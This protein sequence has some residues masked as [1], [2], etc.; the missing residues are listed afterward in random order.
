MHTSLLNYFE[1]G[2]L[3]VCP[4]DVAIVDE[5]REFTFQR[6]DHI[7][8]QIASEWSVHRGDGDQVVAVFLPRCAEVI[9]CNLAAMKCGY[10]YM[11]I[12]YSSPENR[13]S[14]ILENVAPH[15]IV[16]NNEGKDRIDQSS[17]SSAQ[18]FVI[19]SFEP[20][21]QTGNDIAPVLLWKQ[22]LDVDPAFIINTSGSTGVPKSVMLSHR[23]NM[24]FIDWVLDTFDFDRTDII[25]SIAPFHFDIYTL[26]LYVS[27]ATGAKIVIFPEGMA[28]FPA[29][30]IQEMERQSI[31]F[32]FWVPSLMVNIANLG[33]MDNYDLASLR[34]VFFAGEVFPTKQFN[35]WRKRLPDAL[36]VNLYGPIETAVDC[37]YFVVDRALRDDEPIPIGIPCANTDI[38]ILTEGDELAQPGEI[39]ELCVR[40][41]SVA[42]GYLNNEEQTD[43]VFVQNPLNSRYKERIYRTGD[44]AFV[45]ENGE[46]IY[47]GR[48]DSQIKHLGYRIE[49]SEVELAIST[50]PELNSVCVVYNRND[51]EIVAFYEADAEIDLLTVRKQLTKT[52]PKYMMPSKL[53][54]VEEMPLNSNGKIDRLAL[55]SRVS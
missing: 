17:Y 22:R 54:R 32:I 41:S 33:L 31:S 43:R 24:D 29:T 49:L 14:A 50:L 51:K 12:D 10:I 2:A 13:L 3:S 7:S 15:F 53:L 9:F 39:G 11:N 19:D 8:T 18:I 25:G 23:N 21:E 34:K 45:N 28:A 26:E 5:L 20:H 30:L 47:S 37:T 44:L 35:H 55:A 48:G 52:L 38:L 40:G 36:F 4:H 16:T 42:L 27:L 46:I 1:T 6:M